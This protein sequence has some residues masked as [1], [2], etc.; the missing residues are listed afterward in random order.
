MKQQ[1]T[2]THE[3]WNKRF[4]NACA[5]MRMYFSLDEIEHMVKE[6]KMKNRTPKE[7]EA[8]IRRGMEIIN[9]GVMD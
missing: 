3:E 4:E 5:Y 1:N 7:R 8:S 9:G 2:T 6:R